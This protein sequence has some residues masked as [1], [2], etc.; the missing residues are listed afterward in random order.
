MGRRLLRGFEFFGITVAALRPC[1]IETGFGR[2]HVSESN[3]FQKV[4]A[5][6]RQEIVEQGHTP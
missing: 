3:F 2:A 4:N 5:L 6:S 1:V